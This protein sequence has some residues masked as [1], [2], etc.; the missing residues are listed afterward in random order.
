MSTESNNGRRL[1]S[2]SDAIRTRV[3]LKPVVV[4][5]F[6][7]TGLLSLA[8]FAS[9]SIIDDRQRSPNDMTDAAIDRF[10]AVF[11]GNDYS[12][13]AS[14]QRQLDAAVQA[15]PITRH[16]RSDISTTIIFPDISGSQLSIWDSRTTILPL[17]ARETKFWISPYT[18]SR[19]STIST[20]GRRISPMP[21]RAPVTRKGSIHY[22]KR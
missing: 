20:G 19:S 8:G 7:V 2:I 16:T 5:V 9:Q 11:H 4:A 21:K 13:I 22:G 17:S 18:S 15:N 3:R 1:R 12:A 10:W 14:V 6:A